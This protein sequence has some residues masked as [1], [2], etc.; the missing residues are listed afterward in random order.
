MPE[1]PTVK[2]M[3]EAAAAAVSRTRPFAGV[4]KTIPMSPTGLKKF[5]GGTKPY[6][7]T[8]RKLRPWYAERSTESPTPTPIEMAAGLAVLLHD[9][10]PL[11]G[12]A[13]V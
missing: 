13:E 3:R 11:V 10:N 4:A 2:Q 7:P 6:G 1:M 5:L 8:L 9:L 12:V